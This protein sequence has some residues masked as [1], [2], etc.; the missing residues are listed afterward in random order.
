MIDRPFESLEHSAP[1]TEPTSRD[2]EFPIIPSEIRVEYKAFSPVSVRRFPIQQQLVTGEAQC[3]PVPGELQPCHRST[4]RSCSREQRRSRGMVDSPDGQCADVAQM[5]KSD[6]GPVD[7][8]EDGPM[9]LFTG[10]QRRQDSR[11]RN[12]ALNRPPSETSRQI[13]RTR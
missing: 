2:V 8:T 7:L 5:A 10:S 9:S 1:L 13:E 12:V 11:C 6:H 4:D 3:C